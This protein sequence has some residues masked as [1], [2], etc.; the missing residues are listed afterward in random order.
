VDSVII[1][2]S[3]KSGATSPTDTAVN[4][5]VT[6]AIPT[7]TSAS[8]TGTGTDNA[9]DNIFGKSSS[10]SSSDSDDDTELT[11]WQIILIAVIGAVVVAGIVVSVVILVNHIR[12]RTSKTEISPTNSF[13]TGEN[14]KDTS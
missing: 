9:Q 11:L 2:N 3:V 5:N 6:S 14:V 13:M 8:G 12:G 4:Q 7:G 1:E 10:S